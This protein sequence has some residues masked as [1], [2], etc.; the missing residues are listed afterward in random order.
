MYPW[1]RYPRHMHPW[2]RYPRHI[3]IYIYY[4]LFEVN[5]MPQRPDPPFRTRELCNSTQMK[6]RNPACALATYQGGVRCCQ[7]ATML[8]DTRSCTKHNCAEFPR[9]RFYLKMKVDYEDET[10]ATRRLL[11]GLAIDPSSPSSSVFERSQGP[12]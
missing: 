7:N 2:N 12:Q 3:Y 1:H 8:I 6:L 4:I 11:A 10:R 9:E 5:L